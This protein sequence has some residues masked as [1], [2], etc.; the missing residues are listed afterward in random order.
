MSLSTLFS[1]LWQVIVPGRRESD[2]SATR[3]A[4]ADE[5]FPKAHSPVASGVSAE[6]NEE[7]DSAFD[8]VFGEGGT[9]AGG[10]STDGEDGLNQTDRAQNQELFA[11]IAANY[12]RPVK[13]FMFELEVGSAPKEWIEVCRPIL[14][15]LTDAGESMELW[16][17]TKLIGTLDK[18]LEKAQEDEGPWPSKSWS[19]RILFIYGKLVE[20]QPDAFAVDE[21][22]RR[23]ESIIIHSLLRQIPDVGYVSL[24]K[25]YRV[26]LTSREMLFA[27]GPRDLVTTAGLPEELSG[28]IC[29][30]VQAY[31]ER[32]E[33]ASPE[34]LRERGM[35]R[36][37]E[38]VPELTGH[39]LAFNEAKD[40]VDATG[41]LA[42]IK[43]DSREKR[44]D[45]AL[46]IDLL[47]AEIGEVDFVREIQ[48]VAFGQRIKK[49]ERYLQSPD[50]AEADS[51]SDDT[52]NSDEDRETSPT[53]VGT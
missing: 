47:L 40:A 4:A 27:A 10:T 13:D 49:L 24:E 29:M 36:L 26:G 39:H 45:L 8:A 41:K 22:D 25:L 31:R 2:G 19:E 38:K 30:E 6:L 42:K 44:R 46:E 43:R 9:L 35:T 50:T 14:A 20:L 33:G 37:R 5:Q 16:N 51:P 15:T 11:G 17:T 53:I 3:S 23:R 7:F 48:S 21:T 1:K 18:E 32:T 34:E 52:S 28:M 12:A